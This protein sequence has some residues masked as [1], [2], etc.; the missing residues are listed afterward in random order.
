MRRGDL[1]TAVNLR[2]APLVD[3]CLVAD[4]PDAA[5]E[6]IRIALA[7]WTQR[8]FHLQHWMA[9]LW[10]AEIELYV[11]DGA[12]AYARLERDRR[13]YRR[14]GI[15]HAQSARAVTSF[16]RGCAAVASALGASVDVR[17]SRLAESRKMAGR[18]EQEGMAW[19]APLASLV[20]AATENAEGKPA[21]SCAALREAIERA[22]AA[23]MSLHAWCARRQLGSLIGGEEGDQLVAQADA[24][25]LAE[26]VQAPARMATM[27]VPGLWAPSSLPSR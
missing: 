18:L 1:F 15:A 5:R 16:I 8:G 25:M 10:E 13:A 4:D 20:R 17:R 27:L 3:T 21:G 26:G 23:D 12:R 7:T 2:A 6:H 19:I 24:A 9:M 22:T 14:S 11:G